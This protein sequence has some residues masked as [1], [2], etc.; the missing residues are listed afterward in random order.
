MRKVSRFL[1]FC[2]CFMLC[3][4]SGGSGSGSPSDIDHTP[5][6]TL[7]G[8]AILQ[9]SVGDIFTDA[10]ATADDRED[11]DLTATIT[12]ASTVDTSS[13][14]GYSVS[15]SATDSDGNTTTAERLVFVLAS[16]VDNYDVEW[17]DQ[18]SLPEQDDEGWSVFTP[19]SDSLIMYVSSS[20]GNDD[21]AVTYS[22]D[23]DEIGSDVFNPSGTVSAFAT[24]GAAVAQMREGYPDYV[25]LKRGDSWSLDDNISLDKKGR[26]S[27]ERMVLGAYGD[28]ATDRPLIENAGLFMNRSGNVAVVG[29]H[30]CANERNPAALE[31][32]GFD[33]VSSRSGIGATVYSDTGGFLFEDCWFEWFSGNMI[34]S[35]AF[36]DDENMLAIPDIIVRR[37]IFNNNYSTSSHSQGLYSNLIS[38]LLEENIFDH[39]GWYK[40]GQSNAQ[41]EGMAT[42]FNH[43]TYF[44]ATRNTIMRNNIFLRSSSIQNK[45]TS[46][47]SE[48]IN[49]IAAYNILVDNN[50]YAEGEIGISLGGNSDQDNGPRWEHIVVVNN[51]M[52]AIGRSFPTNRT[53]G[54]GIDINDWNSGLVHGNLL[55]NWGKTDL[56]TNTYGFNILGHTTDT[57]FS[58]NIIYNVV[59]GGSLMNFSDGDVSGA[60][61]RI[62][63][64]DNEIAAMADTNGRLINYNMVPETQ[65]FEDNYYYFAKSNEL[66]FGDS[67]TRIDFAAFAAISE[68][69]TSV[70]ELRDYVDPERSIGSFLTDM[71]YAGTIP[72]EDDEIP[73]LVE[74]LKQQ[75]KG[76]WDEVLTAQGLNGYFR[77]GF[78]IDGHAECR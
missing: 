72:D 31:F 56:Y 5:V 32:V 65:L 61:D 19:S 14:G 26:S 6:I 37:N 68:D 77:D 3:S 42:M 2:L 45:F 23:A 78:C 33:N 38:L 1:L 22:P 63:V 55:A 8:D 13:A 66:W 34:Q 29:I 15:Y 24:I 11:G 40:Q 35:W 54:W 17:S 76:H 64:R 7:L 39:N 25:L 20:T 57:I 44:S 73:D 46:N 10:G 43:N 12:T 60:L 51:V 27:S 50:F 9:L 16:N 53:L 75:R 52:T 67:G 70:A 18:F 28:L 59:S 36:D 58:G 4:C 48:G 62:I 74:L 30:F 21:S 49:Q 71:D 47:T 69:T 41:D